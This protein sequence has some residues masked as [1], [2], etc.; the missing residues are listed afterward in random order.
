[1]AKS[2]GNRKM[3]LPGWIWLTTG[4]LIGLFIAFLVY[5]KD[6]FQST[7]T[8]P[9]ATANK[10]QDARAVRKFKEGEELPPPPTRTRFD[11]Y[12]ILPEMEVAVPDDDID[13]KSKSPATAAGKTDTYILQAGAFRKPDQAERMKASLALIG[14]E[15]SVQTVTV[16]NKQTWH[17][18]RIGPYRDLKQL[19]QVRTRLHENNINAILLR[20]KT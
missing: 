11:F 18:V 5:L 1:M 17:R 7:A 16:D 15:A 20:I 3:P 8:V 9:S 14:I 6:N 4:L 10:P 12:T 13:A 19:N 2:R